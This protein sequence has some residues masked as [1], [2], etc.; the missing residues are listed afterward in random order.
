MFILYFGIFL[1]LFS[2]GENNGR[3][4]NKI[5]ART[6]SNPSPIPSLPNGEIQ[7]YLALVSENRILNDIKWLSSFKTRY[8]LAPEGVQVVLDLK[9]KWEQ[10]S[11]GRNDIKIELIDHEWP[12]PSLKLTFIGDIDQEIVIGGHIDSINTDNEGVESSAPG[13]DDNA[14][15]ISVITE[16]IKILAESGYKSK[17]QLTFYA[18]AAEEVGLRGS[19]E[20]A[21][22]YQDENKFVRGV[23]NLDGTNY[24]GSSKKIV[25]I[26]DST[27]SE[28]NT[29]LAKIIDDY[30]KVDWG[31][32]SC[33][34]A[35]SDHYPWTYY[36][37]KASFPAE[38]LIAEENP[39]IHTSQDTLENMGYSAN[40]S[41][42]FAKLGLAYI[43][44]L[45]EVLE[46]SVTFH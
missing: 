7:N 9:E 39:Y 33:D 32:D 41:V 10:L 14:S 17:N 37:F 12:Q 26:S 2:C 38:A 23:L 22:S 35:C 4:S 6:P 31:Y 43:L 3:N 34:Y 16:I 40:H 5:P 21:K 8:Y 19:Y 29:F 1:G 18:Y 44:S 42:L 20:I 11:Q 36:G 13:A 30:I 25:L 45:D 46:N 24:N 15:G 27:S 28:Q